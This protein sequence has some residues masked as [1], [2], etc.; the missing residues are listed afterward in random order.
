MAT[1][2]GPVELRNGIAPPTARL[3]DRGI[4][5]NK[6][7]RGGRGTVGGFVPQTETTAR[8]A[9]RRAEPTARPAAGR[10]R[11]LRRSQGP[12]R[13]GERRIAASDRPFAARARAG[14]RADGRVDCTARFAGERYYRSGGQSTRATAV[15]DRIAEPARRARGGTGAKEYERPEPARPDSAE[16]SGEPRPGPQRVH[17]HY[18]C[19]RRTAQS[20]DVDP[21]GNGGQR[22]LH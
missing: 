14:K 20:Q 10:D 15:F 1:A 12:G 19:R 3:R 18:H 22:R 6:S 8:T 5:G 13:S 7:R 21:G 17:Y 9:Y 16:V 2:V 4:D 11:H